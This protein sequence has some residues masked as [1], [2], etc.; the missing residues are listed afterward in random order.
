M[1]SDASPSS[2][3]LLIS[4]KGSHF[5]TILLLLIIT[6][7]PPLLPDDGASRFHDNRRVLFRPRNRQ[8]FLKLITALLINCKMSQLVRENATPYSFGDPSAFVFARVNMGLATLVSSFAQGKKCLHSSAGFWLSS[9]L[10]C[11]ISGVMFGQELKSSQDDTRRDCVIQ[12]L[13][14]ILTQNRAKHTRHVHYNNRRN[15]LWYS[16]ILDQIL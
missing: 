3:L 16:R 11:V 4:L 5:Y 10:G 13:L 1:N 14:A 15:G 12:Q 7:V 2:R 8:H 9:Q 6:T